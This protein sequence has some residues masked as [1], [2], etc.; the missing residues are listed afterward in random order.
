MLPCPKCKS[1]KTTKGGFV[2]SK[3]RY[4]CNG[5]GIS[6][7]KRTADYKMKIKPDMRNKILDMYNTKKDY[8]NKYDNKHK[9]TYTTR[10]IANSLGVSKS[11]VHKLVFANAKNVIHKVYK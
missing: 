4:L 1:K 10:E 5:C 3:Q 2:N 6:F 9:K 8:I 11:F 7:I